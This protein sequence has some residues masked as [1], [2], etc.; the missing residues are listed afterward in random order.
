MSSTIFTSANYDGTANFT[1]PDGYTS[2]SGEAFLGATS[3]VTITIPASVTS[4]GVEAF[5]GCSI[6]TT[7][8]F[9]DISNSELTSIGANAFR[10][11]IEL[12]SMTLPATVNNIDNF[13]FSLCSKLYSINIPVLVTI[14][15]DYTFIG[16]SSLT[17]VI[18]DAPSQLTTIKYNV[19]DGATSLSSITIPASVKTFNNFV[20]NNCSNLTTVTFA[21]VSQLTTLGQA[22]FKGTGLTSITIPA[23]VTSIGNDTFID[24]ALLE[25]IYVDGSN[26]NYTADVNNVLFNKTET[27]LIKYP[28]GKSDTYYNIPDS[29]TT[30]VDNAFINT[31]ISLLYASPTLISANSWNM[32]NTNTIGNK[33]DVLVKSNVPISP[34]CFPARTPILTDQGNIA[35]SK[36]NPKIHTIRGKKI[37]AI[38]QTIS[39]DKHIISIEKDAIAKNIPCNTTQISKD[40]KL[41]YKGVM[42]KAI[43]LVGVCKG[44]SE[45]H[46]NGEILYNVILQK[47]D[48]MVI[49]NLICET[50]HPSHMIAK[51]ITSNNNQVGKNQLFAKL[52]RI[53][54][55]NDIPAFKKLYTALK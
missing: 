27:I 1:I 44:I 7:V 10:S 45:I 55:K 18:F 9:D 50:L 42:T 46:Y 35:I 48:R 54:L 21:T 17:D 40:H 29:V 23:S 32:N 8:T 26:S 12:S 3:L 6:L 38:S 5:K 2:I 20:F 47:Y 33:V 41:L 52:N 11:A 37:V 13:A 31:D 15:N 28:E 24:A 14:L 4:I 51:I 49:N 36:L 25:T 22:M 30:I 43:D 53:I 34:I 39:L 19:F 16:A